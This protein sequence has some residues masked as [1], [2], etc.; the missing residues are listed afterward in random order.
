MICLKRDP[1]RNCLSGIINA[2]GP[3]VSTSLFYVY[4]SVQCRQKHPS[5]WPVGNEFSVSTAKTQCVHFILLR[6]LH[7]HPTHSLNNIT[8]PFD[9][10][11]MLPC[12]FNASKPHFRWFLVKCKRPMK[13]LKGL[14]RRLNDSAPTS[15]FPSLL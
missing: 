12:L 7:P 10:S 11:V 13:I 4:R 2:V 5:L 9:P 1:V 6:S 3:S 15:L 8:L 14:G